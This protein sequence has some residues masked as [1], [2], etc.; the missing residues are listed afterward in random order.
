MSDVVAIPTLATERLLLRP[1]RLDDFDAYAAMWADP[2]VTRFIGGVPFTREQSWT[3]FLRQIGLWYHLGFGFLAIEDKA[4]GV[5]AG[6][7][8]F[9]DLYR[10]IEPSIE[11][12]MEAGW[13]LVPAMQ[14]RG[15]AEEAM[16]AALTWAEMHGPR[17]RLTA[18]IDP[19]NTASLRVAARLGF[20]EFARSVYSGNAIVMLERP[21][22]TS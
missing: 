2:H 13:G 4:S 10:A 6:E 21:R 12:T 9:H 5:F 11:G 14:G 7:C 16:R 22:R 20:V 19:G 1:Y 15:L 3:R 8:G 18:I 17:D